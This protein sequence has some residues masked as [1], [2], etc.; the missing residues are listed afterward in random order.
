MT[1]VTLAPVHR[2]VRR[3][4]GL[5]TKIYLA[6]AGA[7][8][9]TVAASVIAWISFVELGQLQR[10]ITREHIPSITDSLRLARQSALL[11]ATAPALV[12][13]ADEPDRGRVMD[14]LL[15]QQRVLDASIDKLA[16][17]MADDTDSGNDL[18][19]VAEIRK[20]SHGL[21]GI[22]D[23]LDASVGRQIALRSDL[24]RRTEGAAR[25]HRRLLALLAPL[26]DDATLYLVTGFRTLDD[27]APD[28]PDRRFT[29]DNLLSYAAIGQLS[30]EGNLIGGLLA[31]AAN[32]PDAALLG[33]LRERFLA[34]S[35]RFERARDSAALPQG[36]AL[37]ETSSSLIALGQGDRSIFATR[38]QLLREQRAAGELIA[39][40]RSMAA[41][42][43]AE[44]DELIKRVEARTERAVAASNRA[45]DV[46]ETLLFLLNAISIIGAIVI[47][48]GYVAR[49]LTAPIVH[50]T[51]AAADFEALRFDPARLAGVRER[52]DELGDLARTF[53]RMAAEVQARTET[54]D[55]LVRE[56]THELNEKNAALEESMKQI[57]DELQMAQRMQLSILPKSYPELPQLE[58]YA[59]MRA[60][61]EVGGD[62]YDIFELDRDRVAIVIADVSG[63]GVPA[64]LFMAVSCTMIKSVASRGGSPGEVLAQVN[65]RLCEGNADEIFV[66]VFYGVI[67]HRAG[68]LTYANGGHNPPYLTRKSRRVDALRTTG[69]I[70]LGVFAGLDYEEQTID[71]RPE[72][73]LFFYTDGITEAFDPSGN[74]FSELRL[75]TVLYESQGLS[76]EALGSRVIGDV[77]SFANGAPQSDD[78]TCVVVRYRT[79]VDHAVAA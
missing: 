6:I 18:A 15:A 49:R 72:D 30:I 35:E 63:K 3:A 55:Q 9:F 60:A 54:L 65:D 56:R 32:T 67:D 52:H 61:R 2:G 16:R 66:T 14:A 48:W 41:G 78:I 50:I 21:A 8:G 23:R 57:A 76:V 7:V 34:A 73:T 19:R 25:Y 33:P 74:M 58:M 28:P 79:A 13:A 39:Q 1:A 47:G 75:K 26:L 42:L 68:T 5:S 70:A 38:E 12:S 37:R 29:K 59:R 69:G 17:D 22:L 11:A 40:S 77:E 45:I 51:S 43:T 31:E 62:F 53:T 71:L 4:L 36:D 46:G 10:Q 20:E 44:V 27:T 64:A 24:T